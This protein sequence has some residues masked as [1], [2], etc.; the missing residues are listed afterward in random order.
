MT[1][2]IVM[3]CLLA[4][5]ALVYFGAERAREAMRPAAEA[6]GGDDGAVI[7]ELRDLLYC[8]QT[9]DEGLDAFAR[10][11]EL[12]RAVGQVRAGDYDGALATLGGLEAAGE[13]P[14]YLPFWVVT[15]AA[16]RG[17]GRVEEARA[18]MRR[19]L[20]SEEA[21][22]RLQ[23]WSILRELGETPPPPPEGREVLGVVVENADFDGVVIIAGYADGVGRLF[24]SGGGGVIGE[25]L[26]EPVQK[27]AKELVL[28][29]AK[30]A[31]GLEP[32]TRR[33]L[34]PRGTVLVTLLTPSGPLVV[35][36][37]VE[38]IDQTSHP[39][40]MAFLKAGLLFSELT[41][42]YTEK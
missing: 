28:E 8:D 31:P 29:G 12:R 1:V 21:R 42:V 14:G 25:P 16:Q 37:E 22:V 41:K 39:L 2:F 18:A 24:L 5:S 9:L 20:S 30:V 17:A 10:E 19:P 34:P 40:H 26:P 38:H 32:G 27:A 35:D 13:Q 7:L 4:A 11:E 33:A 15:A 3:V 36:E 23:A 6:E